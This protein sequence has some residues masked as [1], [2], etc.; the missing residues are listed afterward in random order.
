MERSQPP[1]ANG[2]I[3]YDTIRLGHSSLARVA[4][5][6]YSRD[7]ERSSRQNG[8]ILRDVTKGKVARRALQDRNSHERS[9]IVQK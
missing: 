1:L 7:T 9:E 8:Q 2:A 4:S 5:P 3:R 6:N